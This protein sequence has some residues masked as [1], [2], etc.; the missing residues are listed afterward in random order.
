MTIRATR[1]VANYY[2]APDKH[3]VADDSDFPI[4]SAR[5]FDI[6]REAGKNDLRVFKVQT[7][8]TQGGLSLVGVEDYSHLLL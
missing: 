5:I 8:L 4:V 7:A 2:H 3:A 6:K 1:R